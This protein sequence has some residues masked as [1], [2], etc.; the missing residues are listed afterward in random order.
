MRERATV[1]G[2]FD[3]AEIEHGKRSL[4]PPGIGV[5]MLPVVEDRR[6]GLFSLGLEIPRPEQPLRYYGIACDR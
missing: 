6:L 5:A 3:P 1:A 4:Q 2:S